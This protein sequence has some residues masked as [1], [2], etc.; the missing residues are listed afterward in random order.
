MSLAVPQPALSSSE[1]CLRGLS[2]CVFLKVSINKATRDASQGYH[3]HSYRHPM[4]MEC[5]LSSVTAC[6]G[7]MTW[8]SI[9]HAMITSK[10]PWRFA[11]LRKCL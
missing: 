7:T 2:G 11:S 6:M 1:P 3:Y 5:F 9:L 8:L 10:V 4:T